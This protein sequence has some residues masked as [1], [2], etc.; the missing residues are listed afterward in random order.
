MQHIINSHSIKNL[1]IKLSFLFF[2]ICSKI[3]FAQN[4]SNYDFVKYV[5]EEASKIYSKGGHDNIRCAISIWKYIDNECLMVVNN[6]TKTQIIKIYH[7]IANGYLL[8]DEPQLALQYFGKKIKLKDPNAF[9][10]IE[11]LVVSDSLYNKLST[12]SP[13]VQVDLVRKTRSLILN[14]SG[15]KDL[16]KTISQSFKAYESLENIVYGDSYVKMN[17]MSEVKGKVLSYRRWIHQFDDDQWEKVK[18]DTIIKVR[19]ARY[20]LKYLN[21]KKEETIIEVKCHNGCQPVIEL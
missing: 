1:A 18:T 20:Q 17:L 15:S 3:S 7:K 10:K 21:A 16:S 13:E 14:I 11:R 2:L 8:I 4:F 19:R 9:K 6:D 5:D 12:R